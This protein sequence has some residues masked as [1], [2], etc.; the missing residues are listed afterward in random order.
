[1]DRPVHAP[2]YSPAEQIYIDWFNQYVPAWL[3]AG[4]AAICLCLGA[5]NLGDRAIARWYTT[6]YHSL[7]RPP[8]G[9]ARAGTQ[10]KK[11]EWLPSS[12]LARWRTYSYRKN[13]YAGW[14]GLGSAS[15]LVVIFSYMILN[16]VIVMVGARGEIDY[17]AHHC[18]RLFNANLPLMIGLAA[19]ELGWIGWITGLSFDTLN[20]FHRWSG[21]L[22]LGLATIHI[23][24]RIYVNEP[25]VDPSLPHQ[26]YQAWGIAAY[27]FFFLLIMGSFRYVRIKWFKTWVIS[28]IA[29][30]FL[31]SLCLAFHR[32]QVSAYVVFAFV[33]YAS[34]RIVRA[35]SL[36]WYRIFKPVSRGYGPSA[37]IEILSADTLRI[38][39]TTGKKWI[40]GQHTFFHAPLLG[41]GGHPFSIA[42]TFLPVEGGS[43]TLPAP[44]SGTQVFL[45]RVRGGITR[46]LYN[47]AIEHAETSPNRDDGDGRPS[48]A[49]SFP[50]APLWPC[51]T[52][53]SYGHN[54]KLHRY[55]RVLL[56]TGGSGVTF[57]LPLLLDLVR[58]IKAEKEGGKRI[59]TKRLTWVW[60]IKENAHIDWIEDVLR[61]ALSYAPPNFLD[62]QIYVTSSGK[63]TRAP[64]SGETVIDV[65]PSYEGKDLD[66]KVRWD[67][68][69]SSASTPVP[70]ARSSM[71]ISQLDMRS[72]DGA[73]Y[74]RATRQQASATGAPATRRESIATSTMLARRGSAQIPATS[75]GSSDG[76]EEDR[77][78]ESPKHLSPV[79][80]DFARM[81]RNEADNNMKRYQPTGSFADVASCRSTASWTTTS[82]QGQPVTIQLYAGRPNIPAILDCVISESDYSDSISVGSCGPTPLTRSVAEAAAAAI[83]PAKVA[84]GEHRRNIALHLEEFGW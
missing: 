32:P 61:D 40:P 66:E 30:F 46:Q 77:K 5:Y 84:L 49:S 50:T 11:L 54:L 24:G 23:A 62:V 12:L 6:K 42:S 4:L 2:T 53:G 3:Y 9:L 25:Y 17:R 8:S 68:Q 82:H 43:R 58:R 28:H 47:Y 27:I 78:P 31:G 57:A 19:K 63:P 13:K 76:G 33:L 81:N 1:M 67:S 18:G 65:P 56:I 37:K 35:V 34:D 15:Q 83:D 21:R 29:L 80:S 26:R 16:F 79:M 36:F 64:T 44:E 59:T 52:E 70:S 60:T 38:S 41:A 39:Y 51:W 14:F 55:E 72:L 71:D 22:I 69:S 73:R 74:P 20:A 48:N 75:S 7:H 45:I 10:Q